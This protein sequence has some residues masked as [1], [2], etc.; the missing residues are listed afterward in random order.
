M[1]IDLRTR[2]ILI[3]AAI[4]FLVG[5][6]AIVMGSRASRNGRDVAV[7]VALTQTAAADPAATRATT[8][9]PTAT[10]QDV[11]DAATA[12]ATT[13]EASAAC[14]PDAVFLAD[15]TLP[16]GSVVAPG[17][18]LQKSW[19]VQNTGTCPWT[20][21][22]QLVFAGGDQLVGSDTVPLG[23]TVPPGADH[24][25]SLPL[26]APGNPGQYQGQWVLADPNGSTF[27]QVVYYE[28][29]VE[30][31]PAISYFTASR[32][33]IAPG[34]EVVLSWDVSDAYDG[35]YLRVNGEETRVDA[36]ASTSVYPQGTTL[37]ELVARNQQGES[38]RRIS[39][40]V[41][42]ADATPTLTPPADQLP[43]IA[44]F[45]ADRYEIDAGEEALL[46]WDLS[47]AY[48]GAYLIVDGE[49]QGVVAPGVQTVSP[50]VTTVYRLVARNDA[51]EA[52]QE[53][54]IVVNAPPAETPAEQPTP[55]PPTPTATGAPEAATE[56]PTEPTPAATADGGETPLPAEPTAPPAEEPADPTAEPTA[57]AESTAPPDN[58]DAAP[59][60]GTVLANDTPVYA[61]P[62]AATDAVTTVGEGQQ[63]NLVGR[64]DDGAWL[65]VQTP[66][67]AT[68]WVDA[69]TVQPGVD[70]NTLPVT[71]GE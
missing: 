48:N 6:M 71:G 1:Q 51:G 50:A 44:Y 34:E 11:A 14:R 17:S 20:P 12:P 42:A 67:G 32:Y 29:V 37:Y 4:V 49:E 57:T 55:V 19:R 70:V 63:V 35:A 16:D 41:N 13:T 24:D 31:A 9:P 27:G 15:V 10:Q 21:D 39:I 60:A 58:G 54:T 22:Y 3:V 64:T 61:A 26:T 53:L 25:I 46:S 40:V 18:E 28:I 43:V 56:A 52:S 7:S 47:G 33:L 69:G 59:A 38:V 30:G 8:A 62:D 65:Q 23:A 5:V 2:N 68:G 45:R 66:D 36:P